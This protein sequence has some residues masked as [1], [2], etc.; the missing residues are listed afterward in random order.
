MTYLR[1]NAGPVPLQSPYL[2]ERARKHFTPMPAD[3]KQDPKDI[4]LAQRFVHWLTL[5]ASRADH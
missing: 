1:T 5:Y 2:L 3:T 4:W